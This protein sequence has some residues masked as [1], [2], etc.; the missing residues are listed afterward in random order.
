M[1]MKSIVVTESGRLAGDASPGSG[2]RRYLGIPYAAAPVGSL[3]WRPP[4]PASAWDGVR[5][6]DRFGPSAV[7]GPPPKE[8]LYNGGEEEFSEDCLNLNVW[9]GP[10]SS[11]D[12]PVLVWLH[13][14]AY[15]FGSAANP[16]YDGAR[17]AEAGV[18]VV[19]V[20]SRL[21]RLGYFAHPEL[22]AES[23]HGVSGNYGLLDQIAALQWVQR[24]I[25]A[26]GGSPDNVT[27]GGVSA[28]GHSVHNLLSS[29]LAAG[30]FHRAIAQSGPGA[31]KAVQGH[32]HVAHLQDLASAEA[33]GVELSELVGATSVEQL[34][35]LPLEELL[36]PQ[37]PRTEGVWTFD[38][39]PGAQVSLKVF[40][41]A[42]P[43]VDGHVLPT[44]VVSAYADGKTHP[45]PMLVGNVGNEASG[46]P[47][48]SNLADYES[49]ATEAFGDGATELLRLYPATTDAE[50][51]QASW[52]LLADH[53]FVSSGWT[54]ARLQRHVA[55]VWH[56]RFLRKPPIPQDSDIIERAYA[57][58]FH[59]ADVYYAF[60]TY[61][62]RDWPWSDE[63]RNLS[64]RM[65]R[66]WVS[67][68]RDG[69]PTAGGAILWP[70]FDP[71][72]P[73]SRIWDTEDRIDDISRRDRLAFWDAWNGIDAG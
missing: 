70:L 24:N 48:I 67:F 31:S 71:S 30:L 13:F 55:P 34:R 41:A 16:I 57:G 22:S 63:D 11:T 32:G 33:T 37:L 23:E 17:L 43:V 36:T 9:T 12:R 59:G 35:A 50:A 38:L 8:S 20:N 15:Q 42:Y 66:S 2:V 3:R 29:P 72:A 49:W 56:Y 39:I 54:A 64:D 69:D 27:L 10:E 14:G 58:A 52:E 5:D 61:G 53:V 47:Y 26:F 65:M 68:V 19:T 7:Q 25:A 45:V 6:A 4:Q 18:T 21:G 28:G 44:A 40:D 1:S 46:L 60:G 73:T 51:Q 62:A